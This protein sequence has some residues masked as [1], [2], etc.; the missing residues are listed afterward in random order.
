MFYGAELAAETGGQ[1]FKQIVFR[2]III[3]L[4]VG[5]GAFVIGA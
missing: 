4:V 1:F 2:A 3:L 5:V